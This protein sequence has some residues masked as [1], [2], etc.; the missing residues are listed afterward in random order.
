MA[1]KIDVKALREKVLS[2]DDVVYDTYRVE[3]W[4]VELPI[5]TLSAQDLKKITK[6][7]DDGVR[8]AILAV[9][10]GCKTKDGEAVFAET[11]LAKFEQDK[12]FGPVAKLGAQIMKI[13]GLSTDEVKEAKN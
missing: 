12:A 9:L 2:S 13:S 6:F 8:M 10:Y 11:D 1:K 7:K 5:R 3:E 4:D